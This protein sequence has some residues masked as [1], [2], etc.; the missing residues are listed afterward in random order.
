VCS[1][2][3]GWAN[4]SDIQ[5]V[6]SMVQQQSL[7]R[8]VLEMNS[9]SIVSFGMCFPGPVSVSQMCVLVV[10]SSVIQGVFARP[11]ISVSEGVF[12]V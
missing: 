11:S 3:P 4:S 12:L 7:S 6:F 10:N 2:A 9:T 8:C 5:G 1:L